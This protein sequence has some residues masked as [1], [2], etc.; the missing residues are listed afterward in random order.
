MLTFQIDGSRNGGNFY[1]LFL[2]MA[3][4]NSTNRGIGTIMGAAKYSGFLNQSYN[5][6]MFC[7]VPPTFYY[8]VSVSNIQL[9]YWAELK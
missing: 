8:R 6:S 3:E 9:S 5:E 2:D 7:V 1:H 4:P